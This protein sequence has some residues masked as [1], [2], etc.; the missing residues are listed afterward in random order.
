M[1][2]SCRRRLQGQANVDTKIAKQKARHDSCRAFV[3]VPW[4]CYEVDHHGQR[5]CIHM[6][7]RARDTPQHA[8]IF[9]TSVPLLGKGISRE[10]QPVDTML[11]AKKE[12]YRVSY[13]GKN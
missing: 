2:V 7:E 13:S 11:R 1:G 8:D 4:D 10:Y 9:Y 12:R 6:L 3:A 5:Y